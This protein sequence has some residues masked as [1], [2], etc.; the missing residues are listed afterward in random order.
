MENKDKLAFGKQNYVLMLAGIVIILIGFLIMSMDKEPFG[1][2]M[3]GMTVGPIV[4]LSGF[5]VEFFA[6]L[7]KP[8][9]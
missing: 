1:F 2:G 6:V 8:Q 7:R 3:L 9:Q 4:V 5:V